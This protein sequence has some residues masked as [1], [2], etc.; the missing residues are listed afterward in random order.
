MGWM[1]GGMDGDDGV[2]ERRKGGKKEKKYSRRE[3]N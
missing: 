1:D 3:K 2:I